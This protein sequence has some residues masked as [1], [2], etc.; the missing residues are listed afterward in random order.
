M[1]ELGH[2]KAAEAIV[3]TPVMPGRLAAPGRVKL[4]TIPDRNPRLRLT[5][6]DEG[7]FLRAAR[8]PSDWCCGARRPEAAGPAHLWLPPP[9]VSTWWWKP[10]LYA[11]TMLD[12]PPGGLAVLVIDRSATRGAVAMWRRGEPE[13]IAR[14]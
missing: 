10:S 3:D 1:T 2:A 9:P 4:W 6:E 8:W 13:D 14:V 5:N 11:E 7:S 12:A